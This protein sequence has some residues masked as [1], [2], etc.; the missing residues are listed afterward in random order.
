MEGGGVDLGIRW[1]GGGGGR[2][3]LWGLRFRG[4]VGLGFGESWGG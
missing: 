3:R 4:L 1:G 2:F